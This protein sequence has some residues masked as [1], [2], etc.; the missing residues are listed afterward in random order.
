MLIYQPHICGPGMMQNQNEP[1]NALMCVYFPFDG[2]A[3]KYGYLVDRKPCYNLFDTGASKAMSNKKFYD[4][5]SYTT[6]LP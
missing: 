4:E 2:R 6:S 3:T 5:A 1:K